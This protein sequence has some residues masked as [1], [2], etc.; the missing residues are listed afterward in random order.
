MTVADSDF[1]DVIFYW[2]KRRLI[3]N[4]VMLVWGGFWSLSFIYSLRLINCI[5]GVI[6]FGVI[7]NVFYFL[8]P[9]SEFYVGALLGRS[10]AKYRPW[11]FGLGMAISILVVLMIGVSRVIPVD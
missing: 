8:G 1:K 6:L 5:A 7:A 3:Y 4:A 9:L 11:L 10:I 2:E